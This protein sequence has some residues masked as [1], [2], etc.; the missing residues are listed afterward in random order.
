MSELRD[1]YYSAA[2]D[3]RIKDSCRL[4][5]DDKYHHR[6]V[7]INGKWYKYTIMTTPN[8]DAPTTDSELVYLGEAPQGNIKIDGKVQGN[9]KAVTP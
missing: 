1:F 8:M 6:E 9:F 4:G 3:K 5:R 7:F 2:M